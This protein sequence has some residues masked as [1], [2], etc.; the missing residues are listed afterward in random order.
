MTTTTHSRLTVDDLLRLGPDVWAEV[1]DGRLVIGWPEGEQPMGP[2]GFVHGL[3]AGNVY[4]AIK[5]HV[6]AHRL[7]YVQNDGVIYV[8]E[9]DPAGGVRTALVP[10][11][12]F[13]RKEH[14]SP[15][16][17]LTRPFPG[18]PDLAVEIISPHDA[19]A[20]IQAKVERYL[21]AGTAQVW[22]LYPERGQVYVYARAEGKTTV[23]LFEGADRLPSEA[24]FPG[25][26]IAAESLFALPDL[27]D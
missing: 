23:A 16:L 13:V 8:L 19:A 25:L 5:P 14:V 27:E 24:L 2:V 21:D 1:I 15:D 11:V 7:G 4:D 20:A 6:M 10:D 3:I 18:A 22:V 17:D 26:E 9:S 12:S